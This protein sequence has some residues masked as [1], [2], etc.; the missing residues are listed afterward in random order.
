M[1][2][3]SSRYGDTALS[4][5]H[6]LRFA[7]LYQPGR[8]VVVPCD[9]TGRVDLDALSERLLNAYLGARAMVGREYAFPVVQRTH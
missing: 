5:S 1:G 2:R 4:A 7:S 8:G 6:E 9:A 3:Q